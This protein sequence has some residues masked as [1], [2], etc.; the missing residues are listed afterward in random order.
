MKIEIAPKMR[1]ERHSWRCGY[2]KG[3][4]HPCCRHPMSARSADALTA[5]M[6]DHYEWMLLQLNEWMLLQLKAG[7]AAS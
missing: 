2:F 6:D 5:S 3:E 1:T 4:A 7:D